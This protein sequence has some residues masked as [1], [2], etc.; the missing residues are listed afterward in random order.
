MELNEIITFCLG[1]LLGFSFFVISFFQKRR[2][3]SRQENKFDEVQKSIEEAMVHVSHKIDL[4]DCKL[5][6]MGL[7]LKDL[8]IRTNVVE[9]R[10]EERN[11][12]LVMAASL[13]PS[14][15][16]P[17]RGRPKKALD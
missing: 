2:I 4:M 1:I 3:E 12:A 8:N 14:L 10:L 9:T 6:N 16:A 11:A 17:K 13:N 15:P 7:D 5:Q